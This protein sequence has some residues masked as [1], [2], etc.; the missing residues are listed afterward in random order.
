MQA[1]AIGF[2]ASSFSNHEVVEAGRHALLGNGFCSIFDPFLL[3]AFESRSEG[4]RAPS[5]SQSQNCPQHD[6]P[7]T[8]VTRCQNVV[9]NGGNV[10]IIIVA[11]AASSC[12]SW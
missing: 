7:G 3:A 5:I 12:S 6:G 9:S 4:L 11:T 2:G 10:C 8:D 1:S